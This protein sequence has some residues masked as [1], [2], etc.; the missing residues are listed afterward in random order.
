MRV[1][2][3]VPEGYEPPDPDGPVLR[4]RRRPASSGGRI[5]EQQ[6][7]WFEVDH[8]IRK[9]RHPVRAVA[10][11]VEIER[12]ECEHPVERRHSKPRKAAPAS[13]SRSTPYRRGAS[14]PDSMAFPQ[15][16]RQGGGGRARPRAQ[17]RE[18]PCCVASPCWEPSR[19]RQSW[20]A[21]RSEAA[22]DD[23]SANRRA[24]RARLGGERTDP[25]RRLPSAGAYSTSSGQVAI[26]RSPSAPA[27]SPCARA[28]GWAS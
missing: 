4:P 18:R 11:G 5:P 19:P 17:Q 24:S 27:I 1:P 8:T 9:S 25:P 13:P 12:S 14:T 16:R 7:R 26:R 23:V 2:A 15:A 21:C 3:A 10:R 22:L 28:L 6:T 20:C